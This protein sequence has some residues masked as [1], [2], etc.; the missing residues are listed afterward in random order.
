MMPVISE[1]EAGGFLR[2][3]GR[4]SF[5]PVRTYISIEFISI[6]SLH[7][8]PGMHTFHKG[9]HT[10]GMVGMPVVPALKRLGREDGERDT[11]LVGMPVVPALRRWRWE[12]GERDTNLGYT[13]TPFPKKETKGSPR[14]LCF[15]SHSATSPRYSLRCQGL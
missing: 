9:K 7:N 13:V 3:R 1:G 4:R 14:G 11:N 6:H 15:D 8:F 2:R 5:R 10:L 12:D